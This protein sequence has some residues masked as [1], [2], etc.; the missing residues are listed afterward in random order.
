MIKEAWEERVSLNTAHLNM[1]EAKKKYLENAIK[2]LIVKDK[3]IVDY[4]CSGG[5]LGQLVLQ[6]G[7]EWYFGVDVS[8]RAIQTARDYLK[9][10]HNKT[11]IVSECLE[12]GD[13]F[14]CLNVIQHFPTEQ[15]FKDWI[16]RINNMGYEKVLLN[17]REGPLFFRDNPYETM[18]DILFANTMNCEYIRTYMT[19]Y[20]VHDIIQTGQFTILEFA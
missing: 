10:Y 4:G 13:I 1:S 6:R 14:V 16:M 12:K 2:N 11:L 7:C 20:K 18:E 3:I 8:K 19:N 9:A 17:Y 15:Y 5:Y